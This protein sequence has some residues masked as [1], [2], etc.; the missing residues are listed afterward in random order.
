MRDLDPT[1]QTFIAKTFLHSDHGPS[2]FC[3]SAFYLNGYG[4]ETSV[5]KGLA[6]IAKAALSGHPLAQAYLSRLYASCKVTP[7][8]DIQVEQYLERQALNGSRMALQDLKAIDL[9]KTNHIRKLLKLGYAGVGAPWFTD[10]K[11]LHGLTQKSLMEREFSLDKLGAESG[12]VHEI[13]VNQRG[14]F[15]LHGA[16]ATG[17]FRLVESLLKI[18]G[19]K[20]DQLN[21]KGETALLCACRSGHPD[22]VKLLL[23]NGAKASIQANN[24]ESP[25][26]WL[27]S[28]D[29]EINPD[30]LGGDLIKRGEADVHAFTTEHIAYSAFPGS[31]EVD[32]QVEGTPLMWAV[33]NNCPRIVRFLLLHGA[34]PNW[35][36]PSGGFSPLEWAAFYH[37]IECL[38]LMVNH[39]ETV[40]KTP[41][42]TE[43]KKDLRFALPYR[44][45]VWQALRA[46]DKFTMILRNGPKYLEKLHA[47]LTF[48]QQKTKFINFWLGDRGETIYY[49]EA[50][51][52]RDEAVEFMLQSGWKTGDIDKPCGAAGRTP[53]LESV[54]WNRRALF[55]LL[56]DHGADVQA[57]ARNPYDDSRNDWSA[58]HIFANEAHNENLELVDNILEAGL[59][60]DG[61]KLELGTETPFNVAVRKNAFKLADMLLSRGSELNALSTHSSLAVSPFPLTGLGHIIALNARYSLNSLQYMLSHRPGTSKYEINFIVEPARKLSALHLV[62]LVPDG[63]KS[64]SGEDLMREDFDLETNRIIVHEL[65]EWFK[66]PEEL[67]IRCDIAGKTALH[68]AVER[69][70]VGVVEE[71][72]KA[73]ADIQISCDSGETAADIARRLF[74]EQLI[75]HKFLAWLQ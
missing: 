11:M 30:A 27:L 33:H 57:L 71:L 13:K 20:V 51:G 14:D 12:G 5:E 15:I 16:A 21:A 37:H 61:P 29:E 3:L 58:L 18:K 9:A 59:P 65:L 39:L 50:S 68:L 74:K 46:S 43:G 67:N 2:L 66:T 1:V 31:I 24:G 28:F 19:V 7:H 49:I 64:A 38:E 26:H 48:L 63:F 60:V 73:G 69:G 54:R 10:N 35:T 8:P 44:P 40:V 23:D 32:F 56:H 70:N 62:A 75:L 17:C 6:S 42:T 45:L 55:H 52:G 22:I 4:L 47:T 41:N 36:Y 25:L 53:L 72:V 34:D